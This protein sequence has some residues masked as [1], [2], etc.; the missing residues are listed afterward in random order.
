[1]IKQKIKSVIANTNRALFDLLYYKIYYYFRIKQLRKQSIIKVVFKIENLGAWKTELLYKLMIQH[2]RFEPILIICQ[3]AVE[4][5]LLNLRH[6]C[7]AKGYKYLEIDGLNQDVWDCCYPDIVFFQKQYRGETFLG[8]KCLLKYHKTLFAHIPYGFRS[9]IEPWAYDWPYLHKCWQ[10]YYEN[11]KIATEYAPLVSSK[12]PNIY[13]TGLPMMDELLAQPKET[14]NP[15][16]SSEGKKRIIYAPHHSINP[17]NE[18]ISSTFLDFGDT[19]LQLAEKYSDKIQWAFKPHPLLKDKLI[20]IWGEE[21]T[22]EYYS[23]WQDIEWSQYE[24]GKYVGLFQYSDAMIHDCGSFILEYLYTE[25]PVMYLFKDNHLENTFNL[26]Y[27]KAL[28]LH[29]QGWNIADI[30]SFIINVINGVDPMKQKR[31]SFKKDFL[32]PPYGQ[33]ASQNI[34]DCILSAEA[35]KRMLI[36]NS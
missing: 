16:K 25:N 6:Y 8:L 21:R 23:R 15:W 7:N 9:S 11:K 14:I 4:N 22:N 10:I 5:D 28:S 12:R 36:S 18:W 34:I 33:S 26:Q 27:K 31:I 35:D 3:N 13:V 1:M 30:E 2:P 19:I 24:S 20:A 29:Y 32:T 17:D